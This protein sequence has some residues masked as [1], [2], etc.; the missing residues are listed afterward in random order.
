MSPVVSSAPRKRTQLQESL[1]ALD[2]KLSPSDLAAIEKA[3]P[4]SEIAGSRYG[5]AQMKQ[6]DSER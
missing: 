3:L 4:P 6:L 1:G 5:E 2:V